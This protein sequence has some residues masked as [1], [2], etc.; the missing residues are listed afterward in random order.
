ML[1]DDHDDGAASHP[2]TRRDGP[3]HDET[4]ALR[5][6]WVSFLISCA[7]GSAACSSAKEEKP[8]AAPAP[9]TADPA[10]VQGTRPGG[11]TSIAIGPSPSLVQPAANLD[12]DAKSRFYAGKALATQPWVRAPTQT[13]ARDGLG[14]VYN[15]RTCLGCHI[16]G[17]RGPTASREDEPL[18]ASLVRLS[19]PG[20]GPHGEPIPEPVYGTQLQPQS[21]SLGHQLRGHASADAVKDLG[22]APEAQA[23]IRWT[24][25]PFQYPDG[26]TV[27]L[28]EPTLEL[29]ELGYGALNPETRKGIRHTPSLAGVGLLELVDQA[30]IDRHAD[31]D[32]RDG[33]G[34]SGRVNRV[35]DPE[36]KSERP[37]RFGL[38]ANQPSVRVQVAGA[39]SGDIGITSPV[40]PQQPCTERQPRCLAAPSG[41]DADGVEISEE[42]L[43][44]VVFFNMSIAVPERRKPTHPKVVRG[45]ALF[46]DAGCGSC[47]TPHYV[48]GSDPAYPHL[49]TQDIWPYTDML[50]H[51]MGAGLADG[52]EDFLATGSEWRTPPLWSVG[53]ARAMHDD[54]GFLH[55]GRARTVEEAIVWHDGEGRRSRDRFSAL[56]EADRRS[57]VAFVRSL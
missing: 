38:K 50:L 37:G 8:E 45:Q 27:E 51:D 7:L 21:T 32:D 48:T 15:A 42:L 31:P 54:V 26:K 16:K 18:L 20:R 3:H 33:D 11:D 43:E 6:R 22:P 53:L 29:R 57:L 40:F 44:L 41:A 35:W 24:T 52:R 14:P 56:S 47:H 4:P 49:S 34:I 19:L 39:F 30:D 9:E 13:D 36:S 17:G 46:E 1:D 2:T 23:F 12:D 10:P 55:D 5:R 25:V 28:R